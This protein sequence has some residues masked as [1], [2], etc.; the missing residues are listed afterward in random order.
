MSRDSHRRLVV[1]CALAV[2]CLAVA[3]CVSAHRVLPDGR[4]D[5]V[6]RAELPRHAEAVFKRRNAVSSAFL[7]R[8]PELEGRDP[9]AG[10][11]LEVAE[12]AMDAACAPVD[13]L[14][15]AYRDGDRIGLRA[16]FALVRALERCERATIAA[17]QALPQRQP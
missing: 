9:A 5:R 8:M 4:V 6:P 13:A 17:E 15:I 14:A 11:E 1:G 3:A 16:K 7:L 10:A 12:S 2:A